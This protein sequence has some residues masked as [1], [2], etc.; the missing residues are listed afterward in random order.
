MGLTSED[1]ADFTSEEI[2]WLVQFLRRRARL[3]EAEAGEA[4]NEFQ[5]AAEQDPVKGERD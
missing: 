5:N 2:A 3:A 1:I 4:E